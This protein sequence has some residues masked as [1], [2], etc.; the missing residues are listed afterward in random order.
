MAEV[1]RGDTVAFERLIERH[2]A[3]V[4]GTVGRM[5][6]NNSE[7]EDVAQQVFIRVW[8]GRSPLPAN[9]KIHHLAAH[10]HTQSS[11][12]MKPGAAKRHP[13]DALDVH[14]GEEALALT[15]P[16]RHVP[17][18]ELL[19]AEL[20]EA[21][22]KAIRALPEKQ[23]M[24]VVLRRYESKS[25]EQIGGSPRTYGGSG[26]KACYSVHGLN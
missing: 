3:L 7:V 19:E 4:I 11:F 18:E 16:A 21:I 12:S 13:G 15:D 14:E 6:G 20:Q 24:A 10:D 9:G 17:D 25:Y 26:K 5:L 1:A 2:Q 22:E 8:K 23:R